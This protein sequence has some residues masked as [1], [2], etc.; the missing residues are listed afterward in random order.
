MDLTGCFNQILQMSSCQEVSEIDE[1]AMSLIFD[2]DDAP[3]ILSTTN[4]FSVNDDA[5]LTT[6]NS[7]RYDF[8]DGCVGGSFFIIKLVVIVWI[9]LEVV[10][11]EFLLYSFF[12]CSSLFKC[13][14]IGFGNDWYNINDI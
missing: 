2:V 11:S 4:L 12:E 5:L 9:H 14:G 10:E 1:F 6:N 3:T 8:F 7:K 13:E